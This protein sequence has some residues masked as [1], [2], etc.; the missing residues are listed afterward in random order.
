MTKKVVAAPVAERE[1][2]PPPSGGSFTFDRTKWDW[3]SN[4]PA[5]EQPAEPTEE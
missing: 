2:P 5:A 3:V 1:I 4:E